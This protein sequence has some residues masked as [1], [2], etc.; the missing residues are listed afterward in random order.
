MHIAIISETIKSNQSQPS[1]KGSASEVY[2]NG[3]TPIYICA[4]FSEIY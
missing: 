4:D 2:W 3:Y 1:Y